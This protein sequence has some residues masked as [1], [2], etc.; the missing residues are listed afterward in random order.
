MVSAGEDAAVDAVEGQVAVH[1][2]VAVAA[3]GMA[4]GGGVVPAWFGTGRPGAAQCSWHFHVGSD[5]AHHVYHGA[6]HTGRRR[7]AL[8]LAEAQYDPSGLGEVAVAPVVS[9]GNVGGN[10]APQGVGLVVLNVDED[11]ALHIDVGQVGLIAVTADA[12]RLI[13]VKVLQL[14]PSDPE[15]QPL[16]ARST[17]AAFAAR[18]CHD[19]CAALWCQQLR[20]DRLIA[21]GQVVVHDLW[22]G[23]AQIQPLVEQ[24]RHL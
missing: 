3:G 4:A 7:D 18:G 12:Q 6:H 20:I 5:A 15:S 10:T 14:V 13:V 24:Q 8:P 23:L 22:A 9:A 16:L 21:V 19:A 17:L 11:A 1:V 2:G